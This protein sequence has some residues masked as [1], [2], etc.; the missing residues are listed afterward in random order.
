M[1]IRTW[2]PTTKRMLLMIGLVLLLVVALGIFVLLHRYN[3]IAT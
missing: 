3:R 1:K 2:S